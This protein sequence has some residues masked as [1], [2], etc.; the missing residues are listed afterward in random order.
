MI[1]LGLLNRTRHKHLTPEAMRTVDKKL[2]EAP[3]AE[4]R[5][6]LGFKLEIAR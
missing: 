1:Y 3:Y 6:G 2:S 4:L 5:K